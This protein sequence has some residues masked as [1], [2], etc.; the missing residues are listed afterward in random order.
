MGEKVTHISFGKGKVIEEGET[1]IKV[2]FKKSVGEKAFVFPDAF[3]K[4]LTY[5]DKELQKAV[6]KKLAAQKRKIAAEKKKLEKKKEEL[7]V[8]E[9]TYT[10]IQ[11]KA[12][13]NKKKAEEEAE[14]E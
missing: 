8:S 6:N 2:A 10:A 7:I 13:Q 9:K 14:E 11:M 4:F 5:D 12:E 3:S 1:F